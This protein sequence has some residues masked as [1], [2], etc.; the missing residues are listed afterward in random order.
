MKTA[1]KASLNARIAKIVGAERT[2]KAELGAFSREVLLYVHETNDIDMVN[3]LLKG[4]T[5]APL[6][7]AKLYFPSFLPWEF[8]KDTATF[9][10]KVT[11]AKIVD[12]KRA[13]CVAF[14]KDQ[15]NTIWTWIESNTTPPEKKPTDFG[16]NLTNTLKRG[17]KE[18]GD[19]GLTTTKIV[20]ALMDAEINLA[21]LLVKVE[22]MKD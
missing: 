11:K 19:N 20:K 12:A 16:K 2:T 3:R 8:D 18:A 10:T 22:A 14:L 6:H 4:L 13:K 7:Y 1:N 9:S 21:E 15:N 5:P 17:M